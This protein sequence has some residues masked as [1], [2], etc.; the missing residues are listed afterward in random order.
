M[1]RLETAALTAASA[2][3]NVVRNAIQHSPANDKITLRVLADEDSAT[4]R[5]SD[6]GPGIAE[7][8]LATIFDPFVRAESGLPRAGYGLGLAISR[9]VIEAHGGTISA[10]NGK[11]GGL[12]VTIRLPLLPPADAMPAAG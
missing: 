12:T 7:K 2:V 6:H 3:E 4:I 9:R 5:I 1:S 10:A 11:A 8:A